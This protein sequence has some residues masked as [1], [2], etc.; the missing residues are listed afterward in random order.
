[1]SATF[2][3]DYYR[4][5]RGERRWS[6]AYPET[7]VATDWY[8]LLCGVTAVWQRNEGDYYAGEQCICTACGATWTLPNSPATI[9]RDDADK[10]R[11]AKLR[12]L[13]KDPC[14]HERTE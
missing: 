9:D 6:H 12:E 11:L 2:N 5:V 1:M 4:V 10:Q 14:N 8:C 7:W 3:T 13:A